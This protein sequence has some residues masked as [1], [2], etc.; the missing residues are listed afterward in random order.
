MHHQ[1]AL[2]RRAGPEAHVDPGNGRA[3]G[4]SPQFG[5]CWRRSACPC[6]AGSAACPT[7]LGGALVSAYAPCKDRVQLRR[8]HSAAPSRDKAAQARDR[9][10]LGFR[11]G[12]PS[13]SN[14]VGYR[15]EAMPSV[16][17]RSAFAPSMFRTGALPDVPFG[18]TGR[19]AV[20]EGPS[21]SRQHISFQGRNRS[22]RPSGLNGYGRSVHRCG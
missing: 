7:R 22:I 3:G 11:G 20:R 19:S 10:K 5:P 12:R 14:L 1:V 9:Q 18:G 8:R 4:D 2:G 21:R 15:E 16:G 17:K 6:R 13:H